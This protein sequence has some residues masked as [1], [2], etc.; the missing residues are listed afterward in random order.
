M[1]LKKLFVLADPRRPF[2]MLMFFWL[3]LV[4]VIADQLSKWAAVKYLLDPRTWTAVQPLVAQ[5]DL[6]RLAMID[7][8]LEPVV[9]LPGCFQFVYRINTGAAFS[10]FANHPGLLAIFSS[11]ISVGVVV[12]AWRLKIVEHGLR[13]PLALI[14]GGAIGNLI[15]RFQLSY[16]IDFI[17]FYWKSHHY[18]TFNIA[19][20]AVCV[21]MGLLILAS[22]HPA[23]AE[24]IATAEE[25]KKSATPDANPTKEAVDHNRP[26]EMNS[27][28][29]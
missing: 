25:A 5:G 17:D 12:W 27:G 14:F 10:I 29:R 23:T 20:S 13:L 22:F 24:M 7:L 15:D 28:S 26:G 16:V 9:I 3:A 21:G 6:G 2:G 1:M 18:P 11:V 4:M 8:S 19:D